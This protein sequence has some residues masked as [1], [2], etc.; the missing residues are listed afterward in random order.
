MA[1]CNVLLR[2]CAHTVP[3]HQYS[4]KTYALPSSMV[5][6]GTLSQCHTSKKPSGSAPA[7]TISQ[8]SI[9]EKLLLLSITVRARLPDS[10]FQMLW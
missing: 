2:M 7:L 9:V 8:A 3:Q 5:K 10:A 6:P 1:A 4:A